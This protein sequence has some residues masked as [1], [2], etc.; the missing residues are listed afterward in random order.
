MKFTF[1][2]ILFFLLNICLANEG[3]FKASPGSLEYNE[4][5]ILYLAKKIASRNIVFFGEDHEDWEEKFY[6]DLLVPLDQE[7]EKKLIFRKCLILEQPDKIFGSILEKYNQYI[8]EHGK[9]RWNTS[10]FKEKES[11]QIQVDKKSESR[12]KEYYVLTYSMLAKRALS[13]GWKVYPVDEYKLCENLQYKDE[14]KCRNG[15]MVERI[16]NLMDKECGLFLVINGSHHH[17]I[18]MS[19]DHT[20][21][22]LFL[23]K[24]KLSLDS[25]YMIQL[26]TL[27]QMNSTVNIAADERVVGGK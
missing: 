27:G 4:G 2:F 8:S 5:T 7:L 11:D 9:I 21:L 1:I 22:N 17:A 16:H 15:F 23:K 25:V 26:L 19:A 20:I 10:L 3:E 12:H 14:L 13:R 18:E 6:L 24:S